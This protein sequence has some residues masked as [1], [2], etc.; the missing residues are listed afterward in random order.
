[1]T[2]SKDIY[3]IYKVQGK[4]QH[5]RRMHVMPYSYSRDE[6]DVVAWKHLNEILEVTKN[7][8]GYV[9]LNNNN[10]N[11]GD[12]ENSSRKISSKSFGNIDENI[13]EQSL[14]SSQIDELEEPYTQAIDHKALGLNESDVE[15]EEFFNDLTKRSSPSSTNLGNNHTVGQNKKEPVHPGDVIEYFHPLFVFGNERGKRVTTI[16]SVDPRKKSFPLTLSN[17]ETLPSDVKV[18]RIKILVEDH[19]NKKRQIDHPGIFRE[20]KDFKLVKLNPI[21]GLQITTERERVKGILQKNMKEFRKKVK[22]TGFAPLD[23]MYDFGIKKDDSDFDSDTDDDLSN[24]KKHNRNP[25]TIKTTGSSIQ[26]HVSSPDSDS[27][28]M[29]TVANRGKSSNSRHHVAL[30]SSALKRKVSETDSP[31]L[32]PAC[33][34]S[35]EGSSDTDTDILLQAKSRPRSRTTRKTSSASFRSNAP[36]AYEEGD[37]KLLSLRDTDDEGGDDYVI[38]DPLDSVKPGCYSTC[39]KDVFKS[40]SLDDDDDSD[41][42]FDDLINP[43]RIGYRSIPEKEINSHE[44]PACGQSK[45]KR[46]EKK[47]HTNMSSTVSSKPVQSDCDKDLSETEVPSDFSEDADEDSIES[48]SQ[49]ELKNPKPAFSRTDQTRTCANT[50][51]LVKPLLFKL[52]KYN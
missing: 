35:S 21:P 16:I 28:T 43:S 14:T 34:H 17:D 26:S 52:Q 40:L 51:T 5:N 19:T 20:I 23:L 39:K 37:R 4:N 49:S 2:W 7:C 8:A 38:S 30:D 11:D 3:D 50:R 44:K 6:N 31:N 48:V 13:N 32:L 45:D 10:N 36:E 12:K 41:D 1:M 18:R 29:N 33:G 46:I 15:M 25:S 42:E 24:T 27:E 47:I 22:A 9:T